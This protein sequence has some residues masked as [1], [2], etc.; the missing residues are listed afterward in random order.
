[1]NLD[2]FPVPKEGFVITHV[3]VV[4]DQDRSWDFYRVAA[5]P[6]PGWAL[7][8]GWPG[9]RAYGQIRPRPPAYYRHCVPDC[10]AAPKPHLT[11][12]LAAMALA[13]GCGSGGGMRVGG[14]AVGR[15]DDLDNLLLA[16]LPYLPH[17][18]PQVANCLQFGL[19]HHQVRMNSSSVATSVSCSPSRLAAPHD[20]TAG[21]PR[22]Q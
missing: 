16:G 19:V 22:L 14:R 1:M 4:A 8:R 3:L 18:G 21:H 2:D 15:A 17:R 12:R 20:H 7:D 10:P 5:W 9:H 11:H 13:R 6:R